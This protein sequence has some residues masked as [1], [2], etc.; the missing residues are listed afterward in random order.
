MKDIILTGDRPTGKLH[1]GHYVGSLMNRVK[2]QN[3]GNYEKMYV[4]I[5]DSQALTDNFDNPSKVRSNILE[6]MLDYLAVGLDPKKVTFFIQ[7][8]IPELT[9]YTFYFMNLV[10]VN[11]L[12]RNP[13]VKNEVAQ[14]NFG[15]S[16]PSGFLNYP[17]SQ[18]AD[19]TLFNATVIP[20]GVDQEPMIEQ[21]NEI[22]R[23]FNSIYGETLKEC[24]I[25]LPENEVCCRL[26]GIDGNAKM[27]KSL[28]NC[29][30]L[31]DSM[32][33]LHDKVMKM[34]TDPNHIKVTDP[35]KIEGNIVFTYLD[36]FCTDN[37]YFKKYLPDYKNLDELK[38]H[39]KRG[40]L[41][42]V[43]IKNFLF[44]I[45]NEILT[46][47]REKREELSRNPEAIYEILKKGTEEAQAVAK[48]NIKFFKQA[49]KIDYFN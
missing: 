6:V 23:K 28:G 47:I 38:E 37:N 22:V 2:L 49:M 14:K 11:R 13:T 43:K 44:N 16:M 46:P 31:S 7:S 35:G 45:L 18:T 19:I 20:A 39:Y 21:A 4:F 26:P 5:A 15:E 12:M 3:E 34:Y 30:Y 29:I 40:G 27:S 8:M 9:E 36:A 42:D 48:E 24:K 10:T 32:E 17:V 33:E 1:L 25:L 41:G